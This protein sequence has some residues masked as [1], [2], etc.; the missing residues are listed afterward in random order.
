MLAYLGERY[1]GAAAYLGEIGLSE[2]EIEQISKRLG[3]RTS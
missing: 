1:G 2:A 3:T